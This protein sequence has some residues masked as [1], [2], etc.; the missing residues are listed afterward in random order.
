MWANIDGAIDIHEN[1]DNVSNINAL[2]HGRT[3]SFGTVLAPNSDLAFTF[4][5]NYTDLYMQSYI[6]MRDTGYNVPPFAPC[7]FFSG[8][9]AITLGAMSF[10]SNKQH[11]AYADVM[12]KQMKRITASLGYSGTF[13]GGDTLYLNPR[14]VGTN[15]AF[16]YQK[17][18]AAVNLDLFKGLSYKTSWNYYGYYL[19]SPLDTPGLQPIGSEDFNS[20]IATFSAR[21]TF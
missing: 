20:S 12:W 3:Y 18:F 15:L 17:P 2:E 13:T 14:I 5:Y 1:R 11:Y 8:T 7:A 9:N 10:Y 4:G 19:K 6:C 21:Y 16:A